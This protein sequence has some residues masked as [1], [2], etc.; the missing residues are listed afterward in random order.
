MKTEEKILSTLMISFGVIQAFLIFFKEVGLSV[1]SWGWIFA[2]LW[3]LLALLLF[4]AMSFCLIEIL[5]KNNH[6]FS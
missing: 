6:H 2:P 1:W 4:G 5:T 3:V